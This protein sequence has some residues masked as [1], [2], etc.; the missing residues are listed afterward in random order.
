MGFFLLGGFISAFFRRMKSGKREKTAMFW[1][2]T[3]EA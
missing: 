2:K 1:R 3:D